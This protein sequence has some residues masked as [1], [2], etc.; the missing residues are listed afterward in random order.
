M[1][2]ELSMNNIKAI[3]PEELDAITDCMVTSFISDPTARYSCPE[4][5]HYLATFKGFSHIFF[6]G[7]VKHGTAWKITGN[8]GAI[9]WYPPGESIDTEAMVEYVE[10]TC[11]PDNLE[12]LMAVTASFDNYRPQ[13]PHWHL[14]MIGVDPFSQGQGLGFKLIEHTLE[15]ID[16]EK[17]PTYLES[18]NPQNVS[19]Y[20]RLGFEALDQLC[21][22]GKP[23]MTPMIR[24][25]Q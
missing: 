6:E 13:E 2:I 7:A 8:A 15:Q 18:S 10:K 3:S 11:H 22:G 20:E 1:E 9:A 24:Q 23:T 5:A 4:P 14:G 16:K 19:L 12:D 17:L 25:A 21:L